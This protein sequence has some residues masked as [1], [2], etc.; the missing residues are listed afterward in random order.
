MIRNIDFDAL[1]SLRDRHGAAFPRGRVIFKQGDTT[2]EMY[3]VLQGSVELFITDA[4]TGARKVVAVAPSGDFFGEM[5]CFGGQPR[6]AG[7]VC[8]EDSVLLFF[9]QETAIQLLRASPRF[10]L[11]VIQRLA[12]RV[13]NCNIQIAALTSL[14]GADRAHEVA[15]APV[16]GA[17]GPKMDPAALASAASAAGTGG[18]EVP[19]RDYDKATLWAKPLVCPVS[20]TRF[21]TLN[22][23]PDAIKTKARESDFHDVYVGLNPLWYLIY[24][25][26]ECF[27]ASYPDDF[28]ALAPEE[29]KALSAATSLRQQ[30]AS[31]VPF[32]GPR[33][34]DAA[35]VSFE[36]AIASYLLRAPNPQRLAGLYHR[37]AWL[38]REAGD[39]ATEQQLLGGAQKHYLEA[40]E[41]TPSDP[42]AELMLLYTVGDLNLRLGSPT[43]AVKVFARVSQHPQFKQMPDIQ[44][45]TRDR[46]VEAR[47][48]SR[49]PTA[50]QPG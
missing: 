20:G 46:W 34:A 26:P 45:L 16:A 32:D 2:A 25:C 7:A 35:A 39:A 27:Y 29:T 10:A 36:L 17:P 1:K 23:R 15:P 42:S 11:G 43:E 3:V 4:N 47:D 37:M 31:G 38:A 5:S 44:R 6:S 22:V 14:V 19:L 18:R 9:N 40:L 8:R 12:D 49:R 41:S 28:T 48:A 21:N 33:D 50:A 30:V 13:N 24:V